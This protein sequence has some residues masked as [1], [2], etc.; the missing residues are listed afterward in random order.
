MKFFLQIAAVLGALVVEFTLGR[1]S[2][3]AETHSA[4]AQLADQSS[5]QLRAPIELELQETEPRHVGASLSA[6]LL[7]NSNTKV[8]AE[9]LRKVLR[10]MQQKPHGQ[11]A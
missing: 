3:K 1:Y 8:T 5:E 10:S 7:L 4:E 9:D 6:S 2:S 11:H